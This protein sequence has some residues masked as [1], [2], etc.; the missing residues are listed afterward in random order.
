MVF[1]SKPA[2]CAHGADVTRKYLSAFRKEIPG[3][4]RSRNIEYV[5]RLRVA[6]RR[7]DT[8]VAVFGSCHPGKKVK[9][10]QKE[11]HWITGVLGRA[12]DLDIQAAC[13]KDYMKASPP[14]DQRPGLRRL[15][16]R[17]TQ[18]RVRIHEKLMTALKYLDQHKTLTSLDDRSIALRKSIHVNLDQGLPELKSF[19]GWTIQPAL[20][21]FLSYDPFVDQVKA[22][23]ELH[24]MRIAAKK[25]RYTLECFAGIYPGKLEEYL[26]TLRVIQDQL[27]T[28]HDCDMWQSTGVRFM[29]RE[30][31]RTEKYLGSDRAMTRLMPGLLAFFQDR[32][33]VRVETYSAFTKFWHD[34]RKAH[35][36]EKLLSEI[37]TVNSTPPDHVVNGN[38]MSIT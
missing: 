14:A 13:I 2:V 24:A 10:W 5:H 11:L 9:N 12:R 15:L 20:A 6:S 25:L 37:V 4:L 17:V 16:L 21:K 28:I 33:R 35:L 22:V 27:G 19:A 18:K 3:V 8:A 1:S 29:E 38:R 7:L 32:N 31:R 34:L 26:A 23:D 36:W 30:R